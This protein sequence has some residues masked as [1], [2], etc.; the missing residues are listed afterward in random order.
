MNCRQSRKLFG[1]SWDDE[2]TQ[3]EREWLEAHFASCEACRSEYED[4]TRTL[5]TVGAL[6]RVEVTPGLAE[7]SLARARRAPAAT[8]R[9]PARVVR[10][11]PITATAA[12][13]ATAGGMVAQWS[14]IVSLKPNARIEAPVVREPSLVAGSTPTTP[15]SASPRTAGSAARGDAA[16][17]ALPDSL[18]DQGEDVEFILDAMTLR[19]GR[20]HPASRLAPSPVRGEQAVITF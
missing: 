6:P 10:W 12:L 20:A 5:E 16:L 13:L 19:K 2:L 15:G 14:G 17:A 4:W 8:D 1:A 3:A 7:R 9:F 11:I 18:L